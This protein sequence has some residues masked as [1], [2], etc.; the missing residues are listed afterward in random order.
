MRYGTNECKTGHAVHGA[1][2][3]FDKI[4]LSFRSD[5]ICQFYTF[6][7]QNLPYFSFA[8]QNVNN[9]YFRIINFSQFFSFN[10]LTKL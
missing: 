3:F 9:F 8:G 1:P 4:I 7:R 2:C 10:L 5:T 6:Y